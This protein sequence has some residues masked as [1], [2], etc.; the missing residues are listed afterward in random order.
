M[1]RD[2]PP[3]KS[4]SGLDWLGRSMTRSTPLLRAVLDTI[5]DGFA[6]GGVQY[7]ARVAA[8]SGDASAGFTFLRG[9]QTV[10]QATVGRIFDLSRTF[11]NATE[12]RFSEEVPAGQPLRLDLRFSAAAGN[13][14][15][16]IDYV[17]GFYPQDAPCG[18]GLP[19]VRHPRRAGR[20]VRLAAGGV[21]RR[22]A[23]V[24][25]HRPRRRASAPGGPPGGPL[26]RS[27]RRARPRRTTRG[28]RV[29]PLHGPASEGS[30][31][32]APAPSPT[33]TSTG[34]RA[35]RTTSSSRPS[36]SGRRRAARRPYRAEDGL[37][38]S[39]WTSSR[40][41]TSSAGGSPT[42]A[43]SATTSGSSTTAAPARTPPSG[44]RSSSGAGTTTTVTSAPDEPN[45]ITTYQ[46]EN[47]SLLQRLLHLA[48]TTS[49]CSTRMRGY[50][51]PNAERLDIGIGRLPV[52]TPQ[53]ADEVVRKIKSG[54]RTPPRPA[55]GAP[56]TLS[57]PTTTS[58]SLGQGPPRPE[59]R[60]RRGHR[61]RAGT[62]PERGEDLHGHLPPPAD[63]CGGT[64]PR[65]HR[66]RAA[67][68]GG[69][70][71]PLELLR[72]R[73]H[74]RPRGRAA[75]HAEQIRTLNNFDRLTIAVTAT[76]SFGRYDI[77]GEQSGAEEFVLNPAG[78]HRHLHH[79]PRGPTPAPTRRPTTSG[80]TSP[81]PVPPGARRRGAARRLGEART[82]SR[83][84]RPWGPQLN[85]RKFNLL[86]DPGMRIGLPERPVASPAINGDRRSG[87][88]R[89]PTP[90]VGEG[91]P[92][93]PRPRGSDHR[94]EVPPG[95][96]RASVEGEVRGPGGVRDAGYN[97][98]V[99]VTVFDAARSIR[100][101]EDAIRYTDGT[102]SV[103]SDLIYRGRA[104]VRDGAFRAEFVVP[105]T[106]RTPAS[107]AA[108]RPTSP[109]A[110]GTTGSATPRSSSSGGRRPT[111]SRIPRARAWTS[112]STTPRSSPAA[113]SG[114]GP[115]SSR[116]SSTRTGSTPSARASGTSCC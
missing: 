4:G 14:T 15:G 10:G 68:P 63:R 40:S 16:W 60:G 78:R 90:L 29:R 65:G 92:G 64:L 103:R 8:A 91:L 83:R 80:S 46:T 107:R 49:A 73:Q 87:R 1:D 44:W 114:R 3:G 81:S 38:P 6:G 30:T 51:P 32:A 75:H 76:C 93:A 31:A 5:P 52:H 57:S 101:P 100:L 66:G 108:S 61:P 79:D 110:P 2:G 17:Q 71:A 19:P 72:P 97:G 47:S 85:N 35:T 53:E 55:P 102:F 39:S 25:R 67:R 115:S 41:S 84:P 58:R 37:P 24:G 45:W 74:Q 99:E 104:T 56:A 94:G 89:P 96:E 21:L 105:A 33:R 116:G 7:R 62:G 23:G 113:S 98:E 111:R 70:A 112:S 59:R 106:S 42:P 43:P 9:E 88:A 26:A 18:A 36:P 86:G 27:H 109:T 11:F 12:T 28:R 34:S 50:G 22:A 48:T 54:T 13:P 20:A 77:A 69:R 95:L 82:T